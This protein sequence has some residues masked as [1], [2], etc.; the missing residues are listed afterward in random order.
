MSA[1]LSFIFDDEQILS[2]A[3][4]DS[5]WCALVD[6]FMPDKGRDGDGDHYGVWQLTLT[7]EHECTLRG[8]GDNGLPECVDLAKAVCLYGNIC[9]TRSP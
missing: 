6:A 4:P 1:T 5:L 2:T 3:R 8:M 7:P 9:L